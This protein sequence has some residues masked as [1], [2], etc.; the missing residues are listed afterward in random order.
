MSYR[1]LRRGGVG[2]CDQ[3]VVEFLLS[4][5]L[6]GQVTGLIPGLTEAGLGPGGF[7][8]PCFAIRPRGCERVGETLKTPLKAADSRGRVD[9]L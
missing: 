8:A 3:S 5:S 6:P 1:T 2:R 9:G 7:G 4:S